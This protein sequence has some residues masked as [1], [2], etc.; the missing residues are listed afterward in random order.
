MEPI[1]TYDHIFF[2]IYESGW[3]KLFM[4]CILLMEKKII[5]IPTQRFLF[6]FFSYI[7][8]YLVKTH[9]HYF[10]FYYSKFLK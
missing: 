9:T 2:F 4:Y 3:G 1:R 7:I 8:P 10:R 6:S 5:S